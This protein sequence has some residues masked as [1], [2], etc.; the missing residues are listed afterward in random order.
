M[1]IEPA[2][3]GR[4]P[5][6]D[7][8]RRIHPWD[9]P[10][11][12]C[13]RS[14]DPD[15]TASRFSRARGSDRASPPAFHHAVEFEPQVVVQSRRGVLLDDVLTPLRAPAGRRLRVTLNLRFRGRS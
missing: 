13:I 7:R 12:C 3:S 6:H 9:R 8:R 5:D 1:G 14:D 4:V 10:S 11:N 15:S 2:S